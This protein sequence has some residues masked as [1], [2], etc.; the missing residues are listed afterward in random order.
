VNK[1]FP[2]VPLEQLLS[3]ISRVESVN[4]EKKYTI[5]GAH[6]YA[7]GLYTKGVLFGSEIR[8]N[9][10]YRVEKGD[11]VYNRLF[12]WKGSFAVASKEN[13][14]CYV[15]NEFPCYRVDNNRLVSEYIWFWFQ[16]ESAW[17]EALG[18]SAGGT[19]TSRNRL[20]EH[21]LLSIQ[22]PLPTL[23]VQQ[24]IVARIESLAAKI[25]EA[26]GL[27]RKVKNEVELL[28]LSHLSNLIKANPVSTFRI[29][30]DQLISLERRPIKVIP[31]EKY[32]EIGIYCFGKGIFHK[33]PR[34]GY[35]VGNKDL[36]L[37]KEGDLILQIT[38]AW[39]G[40]IAIASIEEDGLFA[41]I[42]FPTFRVNEA[43][44]RKQYLLTYLKSYDGIEQL[45]N[46]SPGSAGRNRVLS[47]KRI[48]D[49][50]IPVIP[51]DLQTAFSEELD[52]K[53]DKL[54]ALQNETQKELDAMLPSI[55]D[56]A[57]KGE[58]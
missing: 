15:S 27:R 13:H 20:K 10:I 7:K 56:K 12:A 31:E 6:W 5:L 36:F 58:L 37:I 48:N 32:R 1:Q 44:C 23:E 53:I 22:I 54:K 3:P 8:A 33:R 45:R 43:I 39:E 50:I 41:S 30:L 4:P 19:P 51:L 55:L 35:E 24:R 16:R 28:K 46:I 2:L 11:F 49:V 57:F 26:C 29:P 40:A 18:L 21:G 38:F 9:K 14:G 34:T 17:Q 52:K 25:E 42:R 47:L